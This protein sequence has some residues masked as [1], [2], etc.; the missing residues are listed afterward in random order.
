MFEG[1]GAVLYKELIHLRRDPVTVVFALLIPIVQLTIFGY[2]IDTDVR[3]IPTAVL[4]FDQS[5]ESRAFARALENT[6][7]ARVR[8][9]ARTQDELVQVIRSGKAQIGLMFPPGFGRDLRQGRSPRLLVLVDGSDSQTAFRA[10]A[11]A[12][13]LGSRYGVAVPT[14]VVELRTRVL[15][16]PDSRSANFMVPGLIGIILQV[17]AVALTAFSLVRERERGTLEQLMVTPVG[18]VGLMLGKLLPYGALGFAEV[19]TVLVAARLVFG[20]PIHGSVPLLL[21]MSLAFLGAALGLGLLIS[22]VARTQAQALMGTLLIM[23]PSIL[24][25]G[26]MFPRASMPAI[27]YY[28]SFLIPV[29]HFL[30]ILRGIIIRGAGFGDLWPWMASLVAM[31]VIIV[32]IA[33]ARFRKSLA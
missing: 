31:S 4:D 19:L 5:Q 12:S 16:N 24:L 18:K 26:F 2:A 27:V 6:R 3:N 29:T 8:Y 14:P 17:V 20:V 22:T 28:F 11:A 7:Y 1:F 13:Q 32:A 30:E 10:Q 15:F 33:S 9:E 25:S 23:L 21:V